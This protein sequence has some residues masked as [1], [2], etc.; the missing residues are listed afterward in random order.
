MSDRRPIRQRLAELY[1]E[2]ELDLWIYRPHPQ[3]GG[4]SPCRL[5]DTG[6]A[7]HVHQLIDR[8]TSGTSL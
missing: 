7:E 3:L 6:R 1:T 8:M 4:Q 5:V 2:A